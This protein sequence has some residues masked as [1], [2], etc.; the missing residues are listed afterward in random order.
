MRTQSSFQ[1]A[2]APPPMPLPGLPENMLGERNPETLWTDRL[3]L[4]GVTNA[5]SCGVVFG[6]PRM[7]CVG[8]GI[9][10]LE[11][12]FQTAVSEAKPNGRCRVT[13]GFIA[14]LRG[15]AFAALLL[16]EVFLCARVWRNH[17]SEGLLVL[18]SACPIPATMTQ[19]LG[20]KTKVLPPGIYP[21]QRVHGFVVI[22]F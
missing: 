20:L 17:L 12:T 4:L 2:Y 5:L 9:C 21:V 13:R 18:D 3:R 7:D 22:K 14:T 11:T 6:S 1:A 8:T 10:K 19:K 15:S 16:P